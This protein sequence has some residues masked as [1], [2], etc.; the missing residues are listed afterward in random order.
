MAGRNGDT[1]TFTIVTT[2][3][4]KTSQVITIMPDVWTTTRYAGKRPDE[5]S[6]PKTAYG[7]NLAGLRGSDWR[8]FIPLV[9]LPL[10]GCFSLNRSALFDPDVCN[11]KRGA[12]LAGHV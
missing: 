2:Y 4:D 8:T 11:A 7:T 6:V 3:A 12:L 5:N 10:V 1:H 9:E